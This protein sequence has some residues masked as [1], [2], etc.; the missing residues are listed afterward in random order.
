MAILAGAVL[1]ACNLTS[2]YPANPGTP[3]EDTRP[4]DVMDKVRAIDILP[5]SP[6]Q[7]AATAGTSSA[8]RPLIFTGAELAAGAAAGRAEAPAEGEGYDLNFEN[9][10]ITTVAKVILGD[11]LGAGYAIDPRVQGTVTLAS[12]RPIAKADLPFVIESALRMSNVALI[13][14]PTGYRLIP[15]AEAIGTGTV[16]AGRK[17]EAGYGISIVPLRYVSSQTAL[18]LLDGFATK[19]G[20]ARAE[21]TRNLL[22]IQG[23]STDRRVAIETLL[24]FDAD[25]M[26]GQS[27]G[28]FPLR[29]STPEPVIAEIEKIMDTGEGGLS[30]QVVKLQ[31]VGRMNAV[32]VVAKKAELLRTAGNWISRLDQSDSVTNS[33]KVYRVRYGNARNIASLLNEVFVG[34]SGGG[35]ESPTNQIAPGAGLAVT[36]SGPALGGGTAAGG[37]TPGMSA[38][39]PTGAANLQGSTRQLAIAGGTDPRVIDPQSGMLGSGTAAGSSFRGGAGLL[40]NVRITADV[41]NNTV[42]IYANQEHYRLIEQT[43]QQIDRPQLQVAIEATI[44]EVTLNDNLS[45]GVQFL[46]KSGDLGLKPD[47]GS[48]I[49]SVGGAVLGRAFP[50]FNFLLGAEADPRLILD[51]LHSLTDVKVLSNPSL[52][53]LDN[54]VATLQ[55]GDQVP[56]ATG[57]ATVL[58][59]GT[60]PPIVNTIDYRNTGIILRVIPRV[61]YNGNVVLDIEQEIS[62]VSAGGSTLTPTVAQRRVKSSIAVASGQTVL[63]AGLISDRANRGKQGIPLLDQIPGLGDVFSHQTNEKTRTELIIFI[64]PQIIRDG[65]D[66]MRVAEELR[67]K[68]RGKLGTTQPIYRQQ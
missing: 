11:I 45:Y 48:I 68:L 13:R 29:N 36:A 22:L 63:L 51:A 20:A 39:T 16:E 66:A 58:T 3:A 25:W 23:T 32:M 59:G 53:V 47:K 37:L 57:T 33:L 64:R 50:G 67:T 12:G 1:S 60:T 54:Q 9:A 10:P 35:L 30:Q 8:P 43:L 5:R 41:A 2:F 46:L 17:T 28:I 61:S 4:A 65:V 26:R 40:P 49:N 62:N 6:R 42:L 24:N 34:R 55:V 52:V 21:A 44:A 38:P 56:I 15:A 31:A 14:D 7:D 27:V 19:P 18:K